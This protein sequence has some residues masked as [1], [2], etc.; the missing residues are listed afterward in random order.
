M[1]RIVLTSL[2]GLVGCG[3]DDGGG[4]PTGPTGLYEPAQR[5]EPMQGDGAITYTTLDP[6]TPERTIPL[7]VRFPQGATGPLPVVIVMHGG[8]FVDNGHTHLGDWGAVL[9]TS[10]Y[11]AINLGNATD[12]AISHCVALQIPAAEC[13]G[14]ALMVEPADGGTLPAA[15]YSRP[16]DAMAVL[17]RLDAIA[18]VAGITVDPTRVAVL[19]H[20]AGSHAV[21]TLAGA[22]IDVSPTAPDMTIRDPRFR[23]YVANSPQGIGRFGLTATSWDPIAVPVLIQTGREDQ[24]SGE[25]AASRLDAFAHL[26]G[27]DVFQHYVDADGSPHGA[28]SLEDSP[29]VAGI[30]LTIASTAIAFLDAYV[31]DRAEAKAWLASDA[32]TE[33]TAGVSTLSVK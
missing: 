5:Y 25:G 14:P 17:D 29:G 11:V 6:V 13:M 1:R 23:A 20:S 7:R 33:F 22:V 26:D 32:L 27:P 31:L 9:A 12:E 16:N 8:G 21:M 4:P 28:F 10:G 24:T 2:V 18:A 3:G 30:E 15:V 19:A